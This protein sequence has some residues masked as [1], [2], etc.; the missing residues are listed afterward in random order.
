[1]LYLIMGISKSLI[2]ILLRPSLN[3]Y[4]LLMKGINK[5][6]KL[7][8]T[9][10]FNNMSCSKLREMKISKPFFLGLKFLCL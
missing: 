8:L 1:M 5:Y 9:F 7:R 3:A 2:N 10:W 4:V 6:M